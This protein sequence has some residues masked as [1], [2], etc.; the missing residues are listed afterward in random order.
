MTTIKV[1]GHRN[2]SLKQVSFGK[3]LEGFEVSDAVQVSTDR[4]ASTYQV[5]DKLKKDDLIE[6][7]FEDDIRRFVTVE[8]LERDYKNQLSRG[9][10]P[11]VL[12]IPAQLHI[13]ATSRGA[14]AFILKTL[15]IIKFDPVKEGAKKFAEAWD[16]KIMREPGLYKFDKGLDNS[17]KSE[18]IEQLR[19]KQ[20][21]SILLFIH[22]TFSETA[23]GF[24]GLTPEAWTLLKEYFGSEIYGYDHHT[25]SKSPIENAVELVQKLPPNAKLH[26][27]THS[28]GGLIGELLCRSGWKSKSDPFDATD[29]KLMGENEKMASDLD[30]LSTLLKTKKIRVERFVRVACPSRGTTLASKQV[31][32]WLEILI[33]ALGKLIPAGTPWAIGYGVLTD[34]LLDFKKQGMNPEAIP[35]LAV[36]NPESNFIKMINRLDVE[37]DVD[38]SVIAG[39]IEQS[40]VIGKLAAFFTDQFYSGDHDLAVQTRQMYGGPRR[41]AG[42]YFYHKGPGVWHCS[43]FSLKRTAEIIKDALTIDTKVLK[44]RG[45]RSLEEA[46]KNAVAEF[47]SDL[48]SRSFQKRSNLSQPVVYI[49]PGVMGTHLAERGDRIWLD[50]FDLAQGKMANLG[51]NNKKVEP[52]ALLGIGYGNLVEYLSATHEVIPFPFDWRKSIV[53]EANRFGIALEEKLKLLQETKSDQPIRIVAHSMGGLVTRAMIAQ[54]P[55]LWQEISKHEGARFIMLGTPNKGSYK[56]PRLILGQEKTFRM[57]AML[58]VHNSSEQLLEV[59]AR[60]PGILQLLPMD[61]PKWNFT[62]A[63]TWDIFPNLAKR[64]WIKPQEDDLKQASDFHA[65]L[66][67]EENKFKEN[68]PVLYVAGYA[69]GAPVSVDFDEKNAFLFRGTNQGDGTVPWASGILP[70]LEKDRT[71]YMPVPH[72]DLANYKES[73]AALYDLLTEGRTTRLSKTPP[74]YDRGQEEYYPL[75]DEGVEIYPSQL[76]L[77]TAV[78]GVTPVSQEVPSAKPV[79][80]SVVHGNLSFSEHPVAVG[81]YEGDSLYSAEKHLDYYLDGKLSARH[82]LGLYPGPDG[83]AEVVLNDRGKKPGGAIIVGLGKAGELSPHKLSSSF[84]NALREFGVKAVENNSVGED[85]ELKIS[86][87]LIGTGGMGLTVTSSVDAILAGVIQANK[88]FSQLAET[89]RGESQHSYNIR[90]AEI[91]FIELYKDQ[92]ILAVRALNKPLLNSDAFDVEP[93]LR[94]IQGGWQRAAYEEP[95]GWWPRLYIRAGENEDSSLVFSVPT[96]RARSEESLL[97]IQRRNF[98]RLIA[99]AVKNPNWDQALATA[100]FEL[101]VPNRLKG[102]FKDLNNVLFVVDEK[103]AGYPWELLYDRRTGQEKPLVIQMGMIRQF[104]TTTFQERVI[105]VT[106]KNIM[107]VGNPADTPDNFPNLPGAEQEGRLVAEKFKQYQYEVRAAIYADSSTIMSDLFS[108]DYRVLHLA[109]HGVFEYEY[110]ES[111]ED[112][113]EVFTGM[114]LGNGV[115]LTAN[116]IQNKMHI[117]ELVFI[118]CCHLGKISSSRS[119]QPPDYAY[120]EFAASLSRKLIDMGVKAVIAAGWAVDDA[121]ALTFAEVFY[122]HLLRGQPFGAAVKAARQETYDLHKDR[123]NTWGAYQCYGDPDYRFAVSASSGPRATDNFVDIEE[124]I[125]EIKRR[126]EISKTTAA[127]GIEKIRGD[128]RDLKKG[129]ETVNKDWLEDAMVSD[130]LGAAFAEAFCFEDAIE[131]YDLAIRNGRSTAA[132][133]ALEQAANCRIRLAVQNFQNDSRKYRASIKAIKEQIR[134]LD[135][136]MDAIGETPERLA[137]VGGGYKRLARLSSETSPNDS[138]SALNKMEEYY[139]RAWT[140]KE[141]VYSLTNL[142]VAKIVRALWNGKPGVKQL[143]EMEEQI[144]EARKL[145]ATEQKKSPD[146]F[147]AAIGLTDI[148]MLEHLL[149]YLKGSQKNFSE[150]V[151]DELV[152]EYKKA[153]GQYGSAR[154]I[155]S[156]IEHYAFL[157][158]V[159]RKPD[160]KKNKHQD[161]R[162]V[163]EKIFNSLTSIYERVG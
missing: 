38:L 139:A 86:T 77:E 11:G 23:S 91:K 105:D 111:E 158:A 93:R 108:Q 28:R 73:F 87:L 2:E 97:D 54:R 18:K 100:M 128:L 67:K 120:N 52:E 136:L 157:L 33:N 78:L 80:V 13:G 125:F 121:A 90:I 4:A 123:T 114:V 50:A 51:I 152:D 31:D 88:S 37:L 49:L 64:K 127:L 115:F 147:W 159:I 149:K 76:D 134:K 53:D 29:R 84:A 131:S 69:P 5:I 146:D 141:E 27:V 10:E 107:V 20:G 48:T 143:A 89:N 59:I 63:K 30:E 6:L 40:G 55:K 45:F 96:A 118:N 41:K 43:Y 16:K 8:E 160:S 7:V 161:L 140:K 122:D 132:I 14:T 25:L 133:K 130:A 126:H 62:E 65:L 144:K 66:A 17:K 99:Q 1:L 109:G 9:S 119:K 79:R 32:R 72:G 101:M 70:E 60:F 75:R 116:E 124:A 44:D 155:N 26:I 137:M 22:G 117:P 15:R 150:T 61:D 106:N 36:M 92:A 81:H 104:S 148:K 24:G 71:Y 46:D 163:L 145:A 21:K 47:Q 3:E 112:Q 74:R 138:V 12:E 83:T 94:R 57:L 39:D 34:L 98:D 113:P 153:W 68:D 154:E 129:I 103:A 95:P 82:R 162:N 142:V 102:S 151:H 58:D 156:I 42:R 135:R 56:I 35:G 19:V 85:G 110:K